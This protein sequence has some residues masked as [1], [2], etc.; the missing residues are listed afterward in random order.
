L[1]RQVCDWRDA[2]GKPREFS[3]RKALVALQRGG[4]IGLPEA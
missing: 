1:S 3:S 2:L 4:L